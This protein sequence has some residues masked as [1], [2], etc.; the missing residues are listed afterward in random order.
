VPASDQP[1]FIN[2]VAEVRTA[3]G[4]GELLALLHQV[5]AAFGR[6]RGTANAARTLDLDLLAYGSLI[7][8]ADAPLLPHPR[9]HER[10]FVLAPLAEI[11]P[12][13]VHPG[14]EMTA[15]ELLAALP[16]GETVTILEGDAHNP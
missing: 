14:L 10:R 16:P 6:T 7:R 13:W 15:R 3:R 1:W 12:D 5:E 9:L 11:A 8:C 2:A 4:P